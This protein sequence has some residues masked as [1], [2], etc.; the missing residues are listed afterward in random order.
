MRYLISIQFSKM[1]SSCNPP[2][3]QEKKNNVNSIPRTTRIFC[4]QPN[5]TKMEVTVEEALD[6]AGLGIKHV[7]YFLSLSVVITALFAEIEGGDALFRN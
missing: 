3:E 6:N 2:G 5:A 4:Q 7:A 1:T